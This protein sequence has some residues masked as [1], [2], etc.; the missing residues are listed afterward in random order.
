MKKVTITISD[1]IW[2]WWKDNPWINLSQLAERSLM[3]VISLSK[4]LQDTKRIRVKN[5]KMFFIELNRFNLA[6]N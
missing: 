3:A 4:D 1:D 6:Q 2:E 5:K